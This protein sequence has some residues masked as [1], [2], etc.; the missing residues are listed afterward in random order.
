MVEVGYGETYYYINFS[1]F[2]VR[3]EK[4]LKCKKDRARLA[5]HNYFRTW[6]YANDKLQEI[7][8]VLNNTVI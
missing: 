1:K 6:E 8:A 7:L 3:S 5:Q 4:D 2:E